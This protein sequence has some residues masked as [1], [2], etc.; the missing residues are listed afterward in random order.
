MKNLWISELLTEFQALLDRFEADSAS[1]YDLVM[2]NRLESI[3]NLLSDCLGEGAVRSL[4]AEAACRSASSDFRGQRA[5]H[6]LQF[7]KRRR[8]ILEV[9]LAGRHKQMHAA[10]RGN[11][12]PR[13]LTSRAA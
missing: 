11:V 4:L 12:G 8:Q 6:W 1:R 10:Q 3:A 9:I 7:I 5:R 2:V 13:A